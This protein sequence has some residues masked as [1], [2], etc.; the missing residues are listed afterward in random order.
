MIVRDGKDINK[1]YLL[2][3]LNWESWTKYGITIGS[4]ICPG[5]TV[6]EV[7]TQEYTEAYHLHVSVICL[8][9]K[10]SPIPYW[11]EIDEYHEGIIRNSLYVFPIWVWNN[12]NRMRN[13]F[14]HK[15]T[16]KGRK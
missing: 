6:A 1:Y 14:N 4:K 10:E 2:V 9:P 5:M 8:Q 12:R 11:D 15:E 7:G 3:H 13:P 16:W